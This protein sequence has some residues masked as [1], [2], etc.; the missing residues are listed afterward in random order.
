MRRWHYNM[1]RLLWGW[2]AFLVCT[3]LFV[4]PAIPRACPRPSQVSLREIIGY[5]CAWDWHTRRWHCAGEPAFDHVVLTM[6]QP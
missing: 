6:C 3:W 4:H 1:S 2:L 5:H